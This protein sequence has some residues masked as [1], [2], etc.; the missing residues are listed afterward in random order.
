M[1]FLSLALVTM[2][3]FATSAHALTQFLEDFEGQTVG[4]P[5]SGPHWSV[6]TGAGTSADVVNIGGGH[7]NVLEWAD[8]VSDATI[9]AALVALPVNTEGSLSWDMYIPATQLSG[10]YFNFTLYSQ[11]YGQPM[12]DISLVRSA[13][14]PTNPVYFQAGYGGDRPLFFSGVPEDAWVTWTIG[15]GTY[16]GTAPIMDLTLTSGGSTIYSGSFTNSYFTGLGQ[17]PSTFA[18]TPQGNESIMDGVLFD[19]FAIPEPTSATLLGLGALAL[20]RR[21]RR[22]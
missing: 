7:G 3:T 15:W 4:S 22:E 17:N 13:F 2:M 12:L 5:P 20:T 19:N 6:T 16:S 11:Q 8:P 14:Q 1:K 18:L 21:R 10:Q 9:N